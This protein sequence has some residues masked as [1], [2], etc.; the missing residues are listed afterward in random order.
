MNVSYIFSAML[1][2]S[3]IC[4]AA[5]GK[6]NETVNAAFDGAEFAV[7]FIISML[8]TMCFWTGFLKIAER[9][10]ISKKTAKLLSPLINRLF[11]DESEK[12][13]EYIALNMTANMLGMGNAATPMGINAMK[14][15]EKTN[16]TPTLPSSGM[17]LLVAMNT[18][19]VQIM[20]TTILSLR[21]A[22]QS[23]S[24]EKIIPLIWIASLGGFASAVISAK[25]M[26]KFKKRG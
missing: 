4:G 11:K 8:G 16:S 12:S 9:S 14:E 15:M 18:A 24:P 1:L 3:L 7:G 22:A 19:S 17:R 2:I 10:S 26:D 23:A 21:T 13:K 6:L 25:A 20:P 5:T